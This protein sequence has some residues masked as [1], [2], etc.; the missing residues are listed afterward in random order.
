MLLS[1]GGLAQDAKSLQPTQQKPPTHF[2]DVS[3]DGTVEVPAQSVPVSSF[4]S[5]EA[6][7]YVAAHLK[8]MRDPNATYTEKGVPR[9]MMP[10]LER[11]KALFPLVMDDTRIA[12]V[13][14]F[15]FTPKDG[16]SQ[17]N[18][19]RVLIDLHG[20]GFSG[21]WPGCGLLESMP[22]ASLGKI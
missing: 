2:L 9:F 21:C 12:S 3:P 10:Y 13:H 18:S 5:P 17:T 8:D 15:V 7:L 14:V 11:Q 1:L 6:K 22:L 4:L 20:G 19:D 16:V